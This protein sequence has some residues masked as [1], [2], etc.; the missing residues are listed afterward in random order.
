MASLIRLVSNQ[1]LFKNKFVVSQIVVTHRGLQNRRQVG[2]GGGVRGREK[3]VT[4]SNH[5]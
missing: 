3:G 1:R 5:R 2:R 4:K